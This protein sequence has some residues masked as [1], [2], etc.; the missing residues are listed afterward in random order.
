MR[1]RVADS[2]ARPAAVNAR[3]G[4]ATSRATALT[5]ALSPLSWVFS[6]ARAVRAASISTMTTLAP[7]TRRASASPA[8][9]T[10][11]PRSTTRSP[12]FAGQ[13]AARR[14]A[15]WPTRCP[16][17]GCLSRS[18]PP[19]TASSV[20]SAGIRAKLVSETG[21]VQQCARIIDTA[22]ADQDAARQDADRTFEH[23]H[24]LVEH[25]VGDV[26]GIEQGSHRRDQHGIVGAHEL[27]PLIFVPQLV[28]TL[29]HPSPP[30]PCRRRHSSPGGA[31]SR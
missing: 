27:A 25:H 12:A 4:A 30:Q 11:A 21:V 5:R 26:S 17:L 23:A 28:P 31:C 20:T 6:A 19:S 10:P 13:A 18:L 9:P 15:S 22:Y 16:P 29:A 1:M 24:V 8:A 2:G 3:A 14:I 7:P